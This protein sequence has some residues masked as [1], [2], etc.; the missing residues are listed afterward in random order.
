MTKTAYWIMR[1]G[2]AACFIG[3]GAFGMITKEAWVPYFAFA[4][5]PRDWAFD[6]MPVVGTVDIVAGFSVLFGPRPVVLIYMAAW[7]LWTALLR[8]LTGEPVAEALERAG[9]YGVPLA[10]LLLTGLPTSLADAFGERR[11]DSSSE[12]AIPVMRTLTFTTALLLLG[13]GLLTIRGNLIIASHLEFAGFGLHSQLLT[14]YAEI[15]VAILIALRPSVTLLL[16]VAA[17]KLAT[18][19]LFPLT[20]APIWEFIERAGSYAAPLALAGLM[21][22]RREPVRLLTP[23]RI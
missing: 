1:V 13:H 22:R 21:S 2:A 3:H 12:N 4:G 17:W 9:N 5:I 6:L 23:W 14:G 8:P 10:L 19:A 16:L 15:A 20:G 11:P 18:E 7:A